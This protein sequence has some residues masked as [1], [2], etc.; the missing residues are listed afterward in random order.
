MKQ[1]RSAKALC[2]LTLAV[3]LCTFVARAQTARDVLGP[4]A[5]EPLTEQQPPAK[6][7]IDR[8]LAE[9]L[10]HC[11]VV[12]QYRTVNL[13]LVPVFGAAALAVSPRIGHIHVN[14]DDASW[15][16][17]NAS[18]EPV[19]LYGLPPGPHKVL[20][21]L[22]T[23]NHKLLDQGSVTFTVPEPPASESGPEQTAMEMHGAAMQS[24]RNEPPAKIIIDSPQ[25]EPL[26]RGVVFLQ[27][28]AANLQIVPV[29]GP[30]A[31]AVSPRVGHV[32]V[33]I[34]DAPWH[35]ADS[36]VIQSSSRVLRLD[37]T[38]SLSSSSTQT[39]SPSTRV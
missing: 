14:V 20:L 33:T 37:R 27:Y 12:I 38:R 3:T 28:R 22:Q 35:W 16:W 17:V 18:G 23:A 11:R 31:L 13:H 30:A 1:T 8:P 6:I 25:A 21:Q 7:V 26:S 39:T 32:H 9:P 4:A 19:I 24:P 10:S 34:D 5:V 36:S 2:G 15:V 29:F